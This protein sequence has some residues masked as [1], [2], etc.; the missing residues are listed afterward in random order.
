MFGRLASDEI[1]QSQCDLIAGADDSDG[2]TAGRDGNPVGRDAHAWR[3]A[4][5]LAKAV[6]RPHEQQEI[7]AAAEAEHDVERRGAEHADRQHGT[8]RKTLGELAVEELA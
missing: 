3:P 5:R 2:V 7:K 8:W 1:R 6:R 4:E